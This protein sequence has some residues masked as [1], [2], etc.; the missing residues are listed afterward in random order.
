MQIFV[1][2]FLSKAD[3]NVD[4][5]SFMYVYITSKIAWKE[6][7]NWNM[8]LQLSDNQRWLKNPLHLRWPSLRE[9]NK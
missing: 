7:P 2:C 8:L 9:V 3:K 6:E 4:I 1:I 5:Y